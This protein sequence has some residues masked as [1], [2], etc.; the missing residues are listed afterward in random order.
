[1]RMEVEDCKFLTM[2]YRMPEKKLLVIGDSITCG[3]GIEGIV[4]KE[5]LEEECGPTQTQVFN[6]N[7]TD[8]IL[9]ANQLKKEV[10]LYSK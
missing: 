5:I 6:F 9:S 3:Y 1:M 8:Y 4:E 2:Q 7:G 10:T